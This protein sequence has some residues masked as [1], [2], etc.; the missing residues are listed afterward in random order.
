MSLISERQGKLN[1]FPSRL[2]CAAL[3]T[4]VRPGQ[5]IPLA[6]FTVNPRE[7]QVRLPKIAKVTGP[8][9]YTGYTVSSV[10]VYV[11]VLLEPR[12][13]TSD[14]QWKIEEKL[15]H[16]SL[17]FFSEQIGIH[18]LAVW[19]ADKRGKESMVDSERNLYFMEQLGLN[20]NKAPFIVFLQI[21]P[22]QW[23][24]GIETVQISLNR[25]P[26]DHLYLAL[27]GIADKIQ[28]G[29]IPN[30]GLKTRMIYEAAKLWLNDHKKDLKDVE[31]T[32]KDFKP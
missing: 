17:D 23:K 26:V 4:M 9:K 16:E 29:K 2:Q 24:P 20:Q 12:Q 1:V 14:R 28:K 31:A 30:T 27:N 15:L 25:L 22:D 18:A 13:A 10:D 32:I 8:E 7:R 11:L 21:H 19:F 5:Q 3:G 6:P